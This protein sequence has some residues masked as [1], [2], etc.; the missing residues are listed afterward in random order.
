[1][2]RTC[3][4]LKKYCTIRKEQME[5]LKQKALDGQLMLDE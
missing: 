4:P 1:M 5:R 2:P 3:P